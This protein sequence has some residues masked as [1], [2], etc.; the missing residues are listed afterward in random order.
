M[1]KASASI[2]KLA[3]IKVQNYIDMYKL[4]AKIVAVIHDEMIVEC[5]KSISD[6]MAGVVS[7][8]MIEAFNHYCPDIP[9]EVKPDVGTHWIH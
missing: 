1:P 3:L 4:Q 8:K 9:M 5:H 2:T 7:G 6:E